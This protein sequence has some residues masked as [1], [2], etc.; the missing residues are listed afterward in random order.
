MDKS[1]ALI[2]QASG[3]Q[4][5]AIADQV[6]AG[7]VLQDYKARKSE[8]TKRKQHFD[9]EVFTM[10]LQAARFPVTSQLEH[11]LSAWSNISHGLVDGFLKWS[12]QRGDK[13]T[14][15][16]SRLSTIQKY[17]ELAKRAGFLSPDQQSKIRAVKGY[18]GKDARNLNELRGDQTGHEHAKKATPVLF[19]PAHAALMKRNAANAR[20]K[21]AARNL[22]II[23]LLLDHGLREEEIANLNMSAISL[24]AATLAFYSHK[25][26]SYHTHDLTPDSL[27]AARLYLATV[28][29]QREQDQPLFPGIE[30]HRERSAYN[31]MKTAKSARRQSDQRIAERTIAHIVAKIGA[32]IGLE[33]L[34][35]HDCRHYVATDAL[36]NGTDVKS[37]Q[38]LLGHSSPAMSLKYAELAKV[39]NK[40]VKL[41][42][43]NSLA[44]I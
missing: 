12:I 35:P 4:V 22:L 37:L 23:C 7:H 40:D 38:G 10:Y 17:C 24:Q 8:E 20:G 2:P 44:G 3:A 34:S 21:N 26:D 19:A 43:T 39:A 28:P 27:Q 6:A 16:N 13:T 42:M 14:T 29:A 9:L 30:H 36:R 32:A 41:S 33:H 5:A 31:P 11:D 1:K 18:R 15:I 25:T